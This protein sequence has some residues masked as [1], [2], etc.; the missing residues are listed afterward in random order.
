VVWLNL[1][2]WTIAPLFSIAFGSLATTYVNFVYLVTRDRRR[3]SRLIR[4]SLTWYGRGI[5]A[6]GWPLVRVRYVDLEPDAKPPFVLV[7]NHRSSSDGFLMSVF[8]LEVVQVVNIW[9]S[10]VPVMGALVRAAGYVKV[11]EMSHEDFVRDGAALLADGCSVIAFPEGTRSGSRV[12]GPF[13]G[14]SFRLAQATGAAVVPL[15]VAGNEHMPP[16]GSALL[17]PG[18]VVVTKL[19][20]VTKEH[21]ATMNAFQLKSDVRFIIQKHLDSLER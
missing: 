20:A 12:M 16:R 2:F 5:L 11:R 13:H 7:A 3:K 21:Y 17:R 15:A 18:K 6:C 14:S 4:R 1:Q 9:P 8:P 10:R 19:P